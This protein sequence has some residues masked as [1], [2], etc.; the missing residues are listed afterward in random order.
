[1]IEHQFLRV[2]AHGCKQEYE[3]VQTERIET[4]GVEPLDQPHTGD[5]VKI[6]V[7]IASG[8]VPCGQDEERE[9]RNGDNGG[10]E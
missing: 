7:Q 3:H 1:M 8:M 4:I 6:V 9:V 10:M 5:G 2:C